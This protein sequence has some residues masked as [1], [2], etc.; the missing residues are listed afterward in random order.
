MPLGSQK[1]CLGGRQPF[2]I[3]Q[4]LSEASHAQS[5]VPA[6]SL[7][8]LLTLTT[9]LSSE[10]LKLWMFS[11]QL[12]SQPEKASSTLCELVEGEKRTTHFC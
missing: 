11:G 7:T 10:C 8:C 6:L 4:C 5:P 2:I 3:F 1:H 9:A 12:Y